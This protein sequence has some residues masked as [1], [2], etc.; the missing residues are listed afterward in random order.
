MSPPQAS[1][2]TLWE[3]LWLGVSPVS[4]ASSLRLCS[5]CV[6][7][8]VLVGE[9]EALVVVIVLPAVLEVYRVV[10]T[11]VGGA[12]TH[13]PPASKSSHARCPVGSVYRSGLLS[14]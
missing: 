10:P 6:R 8:V 1:W 3:E 4:V 11:C 5:V 14:T 7:V 9:M 12:V 13:R 2:L